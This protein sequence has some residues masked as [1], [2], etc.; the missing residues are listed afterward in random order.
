MTKKEYTDTYCSKCIISLCSGL[1]GNPTDTISED[2][3][4]PF[5]KPDKCSQ[6]GLILKRKAGYTWY[7][8]PECGAEI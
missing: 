3:F 2:D 1:G 7:I 4:C 8:C 5:V 6:C